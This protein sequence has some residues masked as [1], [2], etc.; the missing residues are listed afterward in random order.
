MSA[1][2]DDVKPDAAKTDEPRTPFEDE[3]GMFGT[4]PATKE[5]TDDEVEFLTS[6]TAPRV[7][8]S[9]SRRKTFLYSSLSAMLL[10]I[11]RLVYH[12]TT[13]VTG[14]VVPPVFGLGETGL[15]ALCCGLSALNFFLVPPRE[16]NVKWLTRFFGAGVPLILLGLLYILPPETLHHLLRFLF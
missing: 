5:L 16:G 3:K 4:S 2:T 13:S 8:L 14:L 6:R 1:K 10:L 7:T 15:T 11:L 9:R 12:R